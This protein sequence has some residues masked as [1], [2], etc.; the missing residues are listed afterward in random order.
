MISKSDWFC[1]DSEMNGH[2]TFRCSNKLIKE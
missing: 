1:R 2:Y